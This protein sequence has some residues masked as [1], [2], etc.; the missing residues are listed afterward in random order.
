MNWKA[1]AITYKKEKRIAVWFQKDAALIDRIKQLDDAKWSY[2]LGAWHLPDT[3]ENRLK[4]KL[5]P[6]VLKPQISFDK[7]EQIETFKKY[8]NTKRYSPNTVKTYSEALQAFL[9]YFND[10]NV[11]QINNNDVVTFYNNYILEKKLSISYQNQ[12]V[13][14]IKLYFKTIKEKLNG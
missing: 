14:A 9:Y 7:I 5:E 1:E 10:K 3:K 2:T 11:N 13:N 8:L 4:F 12:V 6:L